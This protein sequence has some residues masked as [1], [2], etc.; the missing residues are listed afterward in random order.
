MGCIIGAAEYLSRVLLADLP[1]CSE[2]N[3]EHLIIAMDADAAEK[4]PTLESA[5]LLEKCRLFQ[6]LRV[7]M[8]DK[9]KRKSSSVWLNIS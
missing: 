2:D 8:D 5:F 9:G 1:L 7:R 6:G 3:G 4:S